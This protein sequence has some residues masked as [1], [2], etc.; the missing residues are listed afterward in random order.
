MKTKVR[1]VMLVILLCFLSKDVA[2][3]AEPIVEWEKTFSD[4]LAYAVEQT[5]E[6][7]FIILGWTSSLPGTGHDL[8]LIKTDPEG[9]IQWEKRFGGSDTQY[10]LDVHQTSDGGYAVLC[11][12]GYCDVRLIKMDSD[13]AIQ[14]EYISGLPGWDSGHRFKQTTDGGYIVAGARNQAPKTDVF[15]LKINS[16]GQW[17]WDRTFEGGGEDYGHGIVLT[18]EG[19]YMITG[20]VGPSANGD[21]FLIKT[22]SDG[23]PLWPG[24]FKQYSLSVRTYAWS[25][26][27]TTDEGFIMAGATYSQ[28]NGD[29]YLVKTDSDGVYQWHS[30]FGTSA[31]DVAHDVKHTRDG[32]YIVTGRS[33]QDGHKNIVAKTDSNGNVEWQKT[34]GGIGN[35][36]EQTNDGGYII[37]G[38]KAGRVYLIK[39]GYPGHPPVADA[40]PDQTVE[41][42]SYE[43]AE[44]TLDGSASTDPDSTPGTNDDIVS[45]DW[46]E[47]PAFLGSDEQIQHTFPL[48]EHTVTLIVTDSCGET[49]NDEVIVVVEDTTPPMIN[50]IS[51][52]PDFLWPPNHKMIEVTVEVEAEDICDPEPFCWILGVSSNEPINGPGDGNTEPD[53]EYTDDPLVVLLRAE[54]A[55]GDNGRVYTIHVVCEDASGNIAMADV[56]VTV[57]HD[58]GKGKGKK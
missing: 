3:G 13:G 50:S 16:E 4:E 28:G 46:Y 11:Q 54:R 42:E 48:D 5:S 25:L 7:G 53:W 29:V 40:G 33:D 20:E 39:L 41:Q 44:V 30:A 36:I 1:N 45:F 18:S 34:F 43:G 57:P 2:F 6:G 12:H 15:L 52:N 32:G 47:G 31:Y 38:N 22:D 9:N 35:E 26:D 8:Y 49:D 21:A 27:N 55:G 19:G 37:A 17:E 10:G 24:V 14:W 23:N 51:A 56:E 58:R